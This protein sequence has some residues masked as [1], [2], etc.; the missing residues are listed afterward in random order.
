MSVLPSLFT[1]G[2]IFLGFFALVEGLQ[3]RFDRAALMIFAAA[4]LDA[5]DGALA[6]LTGSESAFGREFDSLA[7]VL[8]FCSAPALLT[9]LWG[10]RDLDRIG[11]LVPFFFVVC[12]ATRL[13]RFNIQTRI[14]D[15]R[16]FAGLPTPA[17][18]G[19]VAA[20]LLFDPE[21]TWRPWV[22]I[23]VLVVLFVVGSL[24]ISTFR[25]RSI[26]QLNLRRRQSYRIAVPLA[27]VLV[28]VLYKPKPVLVTLAI[29]YTASGPLAWTWGRLRR[30]PSRSTE[31]LES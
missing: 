3:G 8:T 28:L 21:A 24:M 10:L 18:A 7:D 20:I 14:V 13:A 30:S 11:W 29:A 23:G 31:S 15:S 17:A 9:Y 19:T 27:A 12:G 25:Y 4:I 26:K 5:L 22:E 6:R 16:Y 2:N 1:M